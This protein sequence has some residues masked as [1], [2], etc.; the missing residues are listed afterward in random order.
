M[1]LGLEKLGQQKGKRTDN[2]VSQRKREKLEVIPSWV[3]ASLAF[4]P[5]EC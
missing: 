3:K 2:A 4:Q 1:S 5:F